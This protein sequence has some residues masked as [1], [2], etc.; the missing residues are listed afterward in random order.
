MEQQVKTHVSPHPLLPKSI[1]KHIDNERSARMWEYAGKKHKNGL[2]EILPVY[3][4][5]QMFLTDKDGRTYDGE[6]KKLAGD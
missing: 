4:K 2:S 5:E 3:K 6:K 1:Q